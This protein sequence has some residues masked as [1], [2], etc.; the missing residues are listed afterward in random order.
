MA[1]NIPSPS[2]LL[3]HSSSPSCLLAH[4]QLQDKPS[5]V[6]GTDG[7][8]NLDLRLQ[9]RWRRWWRQQHFSASTTASPLLLR[10]HPAILVSAIS[11]PTLKLVS[12][13]LL[14]QGR[15]GSVAPWLTT[16]WMSL[17]L[18][19]NGRSFQFR[20]T[21]PDVVQAWIMFVLRELFVRMRDLSSGMV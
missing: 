21:I 18:P 3:A 7:D 4:S 19:M 2:C 16:S 17:R 13:P 11:P 15:L 6:I 5:S 14:C 10:L 12:Y 20:Q 1:Q 9:R 8:D